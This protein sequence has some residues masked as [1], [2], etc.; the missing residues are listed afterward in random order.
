[1]EGATENARHALFLAVLAVV[2]LTI[3]PRTELCGRRESANVQ[4]EVCCEQRTGGMLSHLHG[5]AET[6]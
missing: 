6:L 2:L 1:M 5:R 4:M 3:N